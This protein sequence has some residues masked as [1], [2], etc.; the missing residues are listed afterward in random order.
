MKF[1]GPDWLPGDKQQK[2]Y[3]A[4]SASTITPEAQEASL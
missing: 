4:F 3:W 2:S 1:Y